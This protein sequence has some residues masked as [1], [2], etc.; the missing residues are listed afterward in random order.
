MYGTKMDKK[1]F[2]SIHDAVMQF[3]YKVTKCTCKTLGF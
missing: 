1:D 3:I 2:E